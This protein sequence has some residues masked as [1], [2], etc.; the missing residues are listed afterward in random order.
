MHLISS[1]INLPTTYQDPV[2]LCKTIEWYVCYYLCI[3]LQSINDPCHIHI[4]SRVDKKIE[5]DTSAVIRAK[6]LKNNRKV[7]TKSS[8]NRNKLYEFYHVEVNGRK[9]PAFSSLVRITINLAHRT[10]KYRI[11][12]R[13]YDIRAKRIHI[14][15]NLHWPIHVRGHRTANDRNFHRSVVDNIIVCLQCLPPSFP[16][17]RKSYLSTSNIFNCDVCAGPCMYTLLECNFLGEQS[18]RI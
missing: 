17:V 18:S 1:N 8:S 4:F 11:K 16:I 14:F 13:L 10:C 3:W 12:R 9:S 5:Q 15:W 7:S 6:R 2:Q